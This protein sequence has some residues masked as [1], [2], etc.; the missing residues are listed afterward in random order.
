MSSGNS[1]KSSAMRTLPFHWPPLRGGSLRR[2]G[3]SRTTGLPARAMMT[4]SPSR[5]RSTSFES[6]SWLR[7]YWRFP[8]GPPDLAKSSSTRIAQ[9]PRSFEHPG[10]RHHEDLVLPA[11]TGRPGGLRGDPG[12]ARAGRAGV[13]GEMPVPLA[14]AAGPF[15]RGGGTFTCL[16]GTDLPCPH[17]ASPSPSPSRR[18]TGFVAIDFETANHEPGQC[19]RGWLVRVEGLRWS[20]ATVRI[21][22][23]RPRLFHPRP[24][25][26]LED[27]SGRTGFRGVSPRPIPAPGRG[28]LVAHNA[29]FDRRVLTACCAAGRLRSQTC[30]S[31]VRSGSP[32]ATGGSKRTTCRR[33]AGS[34]D[35]ARPPRPRVG[36]RGTC[37]D[38][39]PR[40]TNGAGG[41]ERIGAADRTPRGSRAT[42]ADASQWGRRR[43]GDRRRPALAIALAWIIHTSGNKEASRCV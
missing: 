42:G 2:I 30:R 3:T 13:L 24:R 41:G 19:L 10:G 28:R 1:S 27:R 35:R 16:A 32:T 34:G 7:G 18:P 38:R 26:H 22:P 4:S 33:S 15:M 14:S 8:C 11:A 31:S 12:A 37:P 9:E 21:R 40:R 43:C 29:P 25:D 39:P 23:P 6:G 36:R 5:A 17:A 20:A